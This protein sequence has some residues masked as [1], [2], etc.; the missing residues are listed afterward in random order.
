MTTVWRGHA[1][2]SNEEMRA[3]LLLMGW[4]YVYEYDRAP[5][6]AWWRPPKLKSYSGRLFRSTFEAYK[7]LLV[8]TET[9]HAH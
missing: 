9:D 2:P 3:R 1:F 5:Y 7:Q 6:A 8:D 4:Q